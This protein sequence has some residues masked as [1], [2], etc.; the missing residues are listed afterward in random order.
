MFY[1]VMGTFYYLFFSGQDDFGPAH[2]SWATINLN[3]VNLSDTIPYKFGS[4]DLTCTVREREREREREPNRN[5]GEVWLFFS[6]SSGFR[7]ASQPAISSLKLPVSRTSRTLQELQLS[8]CP[9]I[10]SKV[11]RFSAHNR[12]V[13]Q[14]IWSWHCVFPG[15]IQWFY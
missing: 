10:I 2:I 5:C 1:G 11:V 13:C 8:E 3:W 12:P 15:L 4:E 9:V 7:S 6:T 14:Y